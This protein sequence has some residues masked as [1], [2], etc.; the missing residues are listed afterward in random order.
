MSLDINLKATGAAVVV[1]KRAAAHA[2]VARKTAEWTVDKKALI[3]SGRV[4]QLQQTTRLGGAE[5]A[6]VGAKDGA[7]KRQ[8]QVHAR[9]E[10][11]VAR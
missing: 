1:A 3:I 4:S 2:E 9:R 5:A 7:E 10:R 11:R 6:E 8:S